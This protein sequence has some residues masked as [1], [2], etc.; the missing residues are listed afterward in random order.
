MIE[1]K[2]TM[3]EVKKKDEKVFM[4]EKILPS[5]MED[6]LAVFLEETIVKKEEILG[7]TSTFWTEILKGG[8]IKRITLRKI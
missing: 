7:N 3:E 5:S 1:F 4:E 6:T 2:I 8:G